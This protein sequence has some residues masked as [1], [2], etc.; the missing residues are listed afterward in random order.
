MTYP[1]AG[2]W[3][4][5]VEL[6]VKMWQTNK[7]LSADHPF[8]SRPGSWPLL[9]RGL[10]FWNGNHV[11]KTEQEHKRQK[12]LEARQGIV[13]P[14]YKPSP[15]TDE[16]RAEEKRLRDYY[17]DNFQSSQIYLLGNPIV[18]FASTVSLLAFIGLAL[19]N[20]VLEKRKGSQGS[21]PN[22]GL[23]IYKGQSNA[24][25][26][27][28]AW[29]MHW[30]PFF[31]MQRQLFLHHYLPALYFAVLLFAVQLN[32]LFYLAT[33]KYPA[34]YKTQYIVCAILVITS[35]LAFAAYAPLTFG[36]KMTKSYCR[37]LKLSSQ[38][39]FDCDSLL[40]SLK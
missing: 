12:D 1:K 38:W 20:K 18:W 8:A 35:T 21:T 7:A 11:P 26:L 2:F 40:D 29:L 14:N 33:G 15:K 23:S 6:N 19:L 25:F 27:F 37:R 9:S 39:D 17:K 28:V 16:E 24:G 5:F 10:G 3:S 32:H 36:L 13:D 22:L 30:T 4:K 31:A 34:F